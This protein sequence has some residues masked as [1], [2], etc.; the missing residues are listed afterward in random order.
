MQAVQCLELFLGKLLRGTEIIFPDFP[1]GFLDIHFPGTHSFQQRI[2][3][4]L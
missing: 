3:L 2:N 1:G 4:A